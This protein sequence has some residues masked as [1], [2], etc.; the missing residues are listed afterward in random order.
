MF[1]SRLLGA[2]RVPLVEQKSTSV[3]KPPGIDS[4]TSA[5]RGDRRGRSERKPA[6]CGNRQDGSQGMCVSKLIV[7]PRWWA[8]VKGTTV[9]FLPI[10]LCTSLWESD[11]EKGEG[12]KALLEPCQVWVYGEVLVWTKRGILKGS[13]PGLNQN[14]AC[15]PAV[16][17]VVRFSASV[18]RKHS[19]FV[20]FLQRRW[21]GASRSLTTGMI[22]LALMRC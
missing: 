10:C 4:L 8:W 18:T 5:L 12:V 14:P 7:A 22:S 2:A 19:G 20:L 11:G 1:H 6:G 3:I 21:P 13:V 9:L 15:H 17:G 16:L